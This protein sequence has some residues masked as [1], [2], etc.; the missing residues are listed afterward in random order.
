M[1]LSFPSPV[2]FN[3]IILQEYIPLGQRIASFR[4][5]AQDE[6]GAWIP[7]VS[8]TT[9]GCKRILLTPRTTARA[10]RL[11][12]DASLATPLLSGLSLYDDRIYVE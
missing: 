6:A 1:T 7:L 4:V 9:V 12:I 2:T 11:R 10:L 3:R 5:E 8:G